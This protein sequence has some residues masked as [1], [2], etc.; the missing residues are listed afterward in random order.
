L[1]S[2]TSGNVYL[3]GSNYIVNATNSSAGNLTVWLRQLDAKSLSAGAN[4]TF[5]VTQPNSPTYV[6]NYAISIPLA[7][8]DTGVPTLRVYQQPLTANGAPVARLN[9]SSNQAASFTPLVLATQVVG[10]TVYVFYL[11]SATRVNFTSFT[12]GG[13]TLGKEYNLTDAYNASHALSV[14]WGEALGS[15]QVI[16]TWVEGGVVKDATVDLSKGTSNAQTVNNTDVTYVC[17]AYATDKKWV[18][19]FCSQAV[20]ATAVNYFVRTNSTNLIQLGGVNG[21]KN[22]STSTLFNVYPYGPYLAVVYQDITTTPGSTIYGYEL[23]NL[24]TITTFKSLTN[25]VS[26]DSG[27]YSSHFRVPS[28]GL[29]TLLYNNRVGNG[30]LTS[31]SVG[32]VL[33]SSYLASVLGFLLTIIAGLFL[34]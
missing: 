6:N 31:V 20:N 3:V 4:T 11:A 5:N 15:S 33:G 19:E 18:G 8:N 30:T 9:L 32:L 13:N 14:T 17:R 23:W 25:Y 21:T 27:S 26:V 34:F 7:D 2:V 12:V 16:A 10:K 29:Y 24:D 28:G 22:Y 1:A